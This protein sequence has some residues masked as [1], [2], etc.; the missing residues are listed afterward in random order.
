MGQAFFL[1]VLAA[2][3]AVAKQLTCCPGGLGPLDAK[4]PEEVVVMFL[5]FMKIVRR[6]YH[7]QHRNPG[8]Q[9]HL[10]Q[11]V[12]HRT[13]NKIVA[14]DAAINDQAGANNCPVTPTF[15]KQLGLQRD[16]KCTRHMESVYGIGGPTMFQ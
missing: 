5:V 13:G 6:Q 1:L 11:A 8:F 9:L 15:C 7:R 14:V 2:L 10:H 3:R 4:V 16:F 12:D